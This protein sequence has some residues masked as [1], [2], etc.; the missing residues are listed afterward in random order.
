MKKAYTCN[1]F[2]SY[3][4]FLY[5]LQQKQMVYTIMNLHLTATQTALKGKDTCPNS[6]ALKS[7]SICEQIKINQ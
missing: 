7:H 3:F 5:L 6:S 1:H 2:V 4:V